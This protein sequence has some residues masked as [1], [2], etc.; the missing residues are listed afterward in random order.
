MKDREPI[1]DG[2]PDVVDPIAESR[3][4]ACCLVVGLCL[5]AVAG[6]VWLIIHLI[7]N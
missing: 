3:A 4:V 1:F 5:A 6:I 2:E 7:S